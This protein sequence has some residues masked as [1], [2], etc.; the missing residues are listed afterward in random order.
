MVIKEELCDFLLQS[1]LQLCSYPREDWNKQSVNDG[2]RFESG[3][4][5]LS[6]LSFAAVLYTAK[7]WKPPAKVQL[8]LPARE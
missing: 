3:R 8:L 1:V 5:W 4:V 6:E 2:V 7:L